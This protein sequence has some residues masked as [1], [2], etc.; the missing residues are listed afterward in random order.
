MTE[1]CD[2]TMRPDDVTGLCDLTM[3]PDD[4]AKPL[5]TATTT[6]PAT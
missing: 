5:S 3:R 4:E 1:R 6:T 2:L